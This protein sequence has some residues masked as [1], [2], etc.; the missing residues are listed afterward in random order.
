MKRTE[1]IERL[2]AFPYDAADYWVVAGAAMVLYGIRDECA[3]IDLGCSSALADR[4]EA[5]AYPHRITPD[6]NR[7]FQYG[8]KME[9]FENWLYDKVLTIDGCPV[10][11]PEGLFAM[12]QALGREK[13]LA[14]LSLIRNYL[15]QKAAS[16][17]L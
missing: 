5:E 16:Q 9:L 4:L 14:D 1:I 11:S 15:A 7:W 10:I 8:E 6:G 2:R 13:D 12:K 3:D 17:R